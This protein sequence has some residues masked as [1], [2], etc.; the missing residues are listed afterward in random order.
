MDRLNRNLYVILKFTAWP[1]TSGITSEKAWLS[2]K[3]ISCLQVI[4]VLIWMKQTLIWFNYKEM[5]L[6]MDCLTPRIHF[7]E[8]LQ[9]QMSVLHQSISIFKAVS[10]V[11]MMTEQRIK[12]KYLMCQIPIKM[13]KQHAIPNS[14]LHNL[15]IY[16][17]EKLVKD[18]L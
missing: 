15:K 10:Q 1:K 17:T 4:F 5:E 6:E 8:R 16:C 13:L 2:L 9:L 11:H 14:S 7:A 12:E 18:E 3:G